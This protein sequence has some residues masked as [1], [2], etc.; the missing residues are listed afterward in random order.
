MGELGY[1]RGVTPILELESAQVIRL[2]ADPGLVLSPS[3]SRLAGRTPGESD[4]ESLDL[5]ID[6]RAT[7]EREL[8]LSYVAGTTSRS[9]APS[10]NRA[11]RCAAVT[12]VRPVM[13][14]RS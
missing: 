6:T 11:L 13:S 2:T 1:R 4:V 9:R 8:Q 10:V 7:A 5:V 3:D 12:P 14:M